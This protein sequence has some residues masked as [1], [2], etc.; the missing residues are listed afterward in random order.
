MDS[1]AES[2]GQRRPVSKPSELLRPSCAQPERSG[3]S[4]EFPHVRTPFA[5]IDLACIWIAAF[6]SSFPVGD[7]P[8]LRRRSRA[9]RTRSRAPS[10]RWPIF[11]SASATRTHSRSSAGSMA[12]AGGDGGAAGTDGASG[13]DDVDGGPLVPFDSLWPAL[14]TTTAGATAANS[15]ISSLRRLWI[16]SALDRKRRAPDASRNTSTIPSWTLA[17]H[18]GQQGTRF[19]TPFPP[20][21]DRKMT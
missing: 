1:P 6:S 11:T 14:T 2:E 17:W 3:P 18:E 20:P 4:P 9:T 5:T 21:R 13:T 8:G 12:G 19:G 10:F 7:R 16:R 15:S